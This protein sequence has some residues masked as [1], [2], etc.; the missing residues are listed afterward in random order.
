MNPFE[1]KLQNSSSIKHKRETFAAFWRALELASLSAAN[2]TRL[3]F[4]MVNTIQ[5]H[6]FTMCTDKMQQKHSNLILPLACSNTGKKS[7]P[8]RMNDG[9]LCIFYSTQKTHFAT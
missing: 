6:I 1:F 2:H 8:D 7:F 9:L 5:M 4:G 3:I